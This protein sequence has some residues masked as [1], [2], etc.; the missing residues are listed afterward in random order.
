MSRGRAA[1]IVEEELKITAAGARDGGSVLLVEP[2]ASASL[3]LIRREMLQNA[4]HD[5]P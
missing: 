4:A 3:V 5:R 1:L 2:P